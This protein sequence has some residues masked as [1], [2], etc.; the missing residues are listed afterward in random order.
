MLVANLEG[1]DK[2]GF[3]AANADLGKLPS[4]PKISQTTVLRVILP[5]PQAKP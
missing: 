5:T 1:P 2:A 3:A 4:A